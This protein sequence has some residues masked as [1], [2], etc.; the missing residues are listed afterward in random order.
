M[1]WSQINGSLQDRYHITIL[2]TKI[3]LSCAVIEFLI[4][5]TTPGFIF[6]VF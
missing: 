2:S 1:K 4:F 5:Q 3:N 6:L